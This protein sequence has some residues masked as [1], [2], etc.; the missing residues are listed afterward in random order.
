MQAIVHCLSYTVLNA[1]RH[2]DSGLLTESESNL[3]ADTQ[4]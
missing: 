3:P 1:G 4:S 2:R